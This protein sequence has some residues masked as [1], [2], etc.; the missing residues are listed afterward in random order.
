MPRKWKEIAAPA[1]CG[2]V[3]RSPW[4]SASPIVIGSMILEPSFLGLALLIVVIERFE[5]FDKINIL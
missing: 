2:R 5:T 1:C 3:R 4:L